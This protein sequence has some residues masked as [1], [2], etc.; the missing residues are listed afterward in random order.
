MV[1]FNL[2]YLRSFLSSTA[3]Q[4][5]KRIRILHCIGR[6]TVVIPIVTQEEYKRRRKLRKLY[7]DSKRSNF[8]RVASESASNLTPNTTLTSTPYNT[9]NATTEGPITCA[10]RR[11]LR[12]LY[13]SNKRSI[14]PGG[15]ISKQN[16]SSS[17]DPKSIDPNTHNVTRT[18]SVLPTSNIGS[19]RSNSAPHT[20]IVRFSL[21]SNLT[22]TNSI[23]PILENSTL[24]RLS[25]GNCKLV[26]KARVTSPIPMIDLSTEETIVED[27]YKG[28][29][30]EYLDHGDQ[31][32]TCDVC[33]AKLWDS[34][35]GRGKHKD[36]K[37]SYSLCC[38]Y[39]KVELP[40]YKDAR[41][42]Y[43]KLFRCV[44][45]ESK[46]F[47]NNIRRYNSMFA[48]TSMGGKVD[49]T[50]NRGNAPFCYRISGENYHTIGSLLPE[51]G[52]KPKFCQLYIY[53]TENELSNSSSKDASSSSA[54][55]LDRQLIEH[56]KDV[57][58]IDNQLVKSYR[59]VKDSFQD[60]PQLSL[61]LRLIGRREKDGRTYNLPT[62]GEVAA[63]IVGDLDSAIDS[64]DIIV[65]TQTDG[66]RVD[67]PHRGVLDV[68]NK[69]RPNCTMRE[70]FAYRLQD[71]INQ[72]SLILNSRRLFQQFLQKNLRSDTYDSLQKLTNNGQQDISKAGKSVMLPSSFTG[73]ARYMMQNYLDAM[74]LCKCFGYPDFF[75]TITCNPKWSEVTRFLRDTTLK[76]EDRPDI[77]SRLFKLKLDAIC[78][79]LKER[80]LLGKA[81]AFVYTIE[82][83]KRGL[84]HA[85]LCLFMEDEYKLPTVD[86]VDAFI[87]AEIPNR[88]EDPELYTLKMLDGATVIKN[89]IELDNRSVV[90]YNKKLLKR[91]QAHINVEW[92]N[93]AGSIKYLFK[94]I[95]KGP[96]RATVV[97]VQGDNQNEE[98]SK[99]EIKEYYDCR[100]I[101]A[102]K[103]SWRIFSNEVHYRYPSVTRLPFHIP[104]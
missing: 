45:K 49:P 20:N 5:F 29:S 28:V 76:P 95:N 54:A 101:S 6:L 103:A 33:N 16:L 68:T 30:Q 55:A 4:Y 70:F 64:R 91:Y 94:Y 7:L 59:M 2:Y 31:C 26:R 17:A 10:E 15:S 13:L 22:A 19:V 99:D 47:L 78:K 100:Y 37:T 21:S 57:L 72:F 96:D 65:E 77:M 52:S 98:P 40:D 86:H 71:R 46:H 90:P 81:A 53:D 62:A 32:I 79:D 27:P 14:T 83:Q 3:Y 102:C 1:T 34:K 93:Q 58:D 8:K 89:H 97:V 11:R 92:C 67:I 50:V 66:Y 41:P 87:C 18:P 38:G 36:G 48:F 39:S 25:P 85:H 24:P 69:K 35:K 63:L 51:N 88:N 12:K 23:S 82:F 75:I 60:N 73:G 84:P 61:K 56:I 44:D 74:S 43:E 9:C 42:N 80:H 104:G